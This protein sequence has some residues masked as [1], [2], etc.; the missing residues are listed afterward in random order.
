MAPIH[1]LVNIYSEYDSFCVSRY[2]GVQVVES[3][4]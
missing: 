4:K 2:V 3:A 1:F